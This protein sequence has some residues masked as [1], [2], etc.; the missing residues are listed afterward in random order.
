MQTL[1]IIDRI[2]IEPQTGNI[3]VRMRKE[4]LDDQGRVLM[5]ELHRTMIAAG[6]D[7]VSQMAV[8]DADLE[9]MGFSAVKVEDRALLDA[10]LSTYADLRA[11]KAT[12]IRVA[13]PLEA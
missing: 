10:A 1:T 13:A 3:G 7:A 4:V 5:S 8:V 12:E 2:E 9:K 11:Q 6:A